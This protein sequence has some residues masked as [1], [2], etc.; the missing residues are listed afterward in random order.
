M[1]IRPIFI[2][3]ITLSVLLIF[4]LSNFIYTKMTIDRP[5]IQLLDNHGYISEFEVGEKDDFTLI[6]ISLVDN[7]QNPVEI[8]KDLERS[9]SKVLKNNFFI[10]YNNPAP[11]EGSDLW[12]KYW[13]INS[14]IL[15]TIKA[16]NYVQ[17][18]ELLDELLGKDNY[19][20]WVDNQQLLLKYEIGNFRYFNVYYLER[21][22]ANGN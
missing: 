9:L 1:K 12:N 11:K 14:L 4:F 10:Q 13:R 21:G 5:L 19:Y 18:M 6:K 15:E 22:K 17:G 16:A 2:G 3:I 8:H 7:I 20:F